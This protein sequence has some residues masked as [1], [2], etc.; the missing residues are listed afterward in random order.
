MTRCVTGTC[1]WK[2]NGGG[3]GFEMALGL[4]NERRE[5]W[6]EILRSYTLSVEQSSSGACLV[7]IV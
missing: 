6:F 1:V 3:K 7:R 2:D 4:R 5:G